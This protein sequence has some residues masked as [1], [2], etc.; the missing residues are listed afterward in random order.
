M[1]APTVAKEYAEWF[2]SVPIIF[3]AIST[4]SKGLRR[5]SRGSFLKTNP[6]I[7]PNATNEFKTEEKSGRQ[8]D[9]GK[10]DKSSSH[11]SL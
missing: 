6:C 3:S 8:V 10:I 2:S 4:R 5:I 11:R 1:N 7:V 9:K